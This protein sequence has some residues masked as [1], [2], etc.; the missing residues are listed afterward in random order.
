M[1]PLL[2]LLFVEYIKNGI[3]D[4]SDNPDKVRK[5]FE[6]AS[7]KTKESI[8]KLIQDYQINVLPG[9]PREETQLPCII[10]TIASEEEQI[11]GLGD[12]ID[13][14][15]REFDSDDYN[16]LDWDKEHSSKYVQESAQIMANL[17]IEVWSDNAIVTSFLYAIVKYCLFTN[18][19]NMIKE[20]LFNLTL[21]G[22]D[23]EPA[24][25][26]FTVFVYRRA[27]MLNLEYIASFEVNNLLI[28]GDGHFNIGTTIDDIDLEIGGI[29]GGEKD[30]E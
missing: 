16:Y 20:G 15:Y 22:G 9:Y 2:D 23:L 1:I 17:R 3:K 26:Y 5:Y 10:C 19:Q 28:G 21:S 27:V 18:R 6:Y 24:P 29:E 30:F 7:D 14:N 8:I 13:E 4:L 12:G 25:E 11:Y